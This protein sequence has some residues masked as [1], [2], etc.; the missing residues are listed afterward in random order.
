MS[1]G[2]LS[3]QMIL[4][5]GER[6]TGYAKAKSDGTVIFCFTRWGKRYWAGGDGTEVRATK[7][8]AFADARAYRS[9]TSMYDSPQ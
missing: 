6:S 8:E 5:T 7:R 9:V 3:L 4:A 1:N 2:I